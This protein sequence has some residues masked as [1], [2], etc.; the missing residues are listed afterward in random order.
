MSFLTLML[1]ILS[2]MPREGVS[3]CTG[4][5]CWLGLNLNTL[6]AVC[7]PPD[8]HHPQNSE[9]RTLATK[10]LLIRFNVFSSYYNDFAFGHVLH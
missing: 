4:L 3:D 7:I 10:P 5:S 6:P 8:H 2:S 9:S 1:L